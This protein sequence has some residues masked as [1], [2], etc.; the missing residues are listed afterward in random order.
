MAEA[1]TNWRQ[2]ECAGRNASERRASLEKDD[3]QADP[4]AISGKADPTGLN[5]RRV[6]PALRELRK[7][8]GSA[9]IL[10][11]HDLGLVAEQCERV[12]VMYAGHIVEECNTAELFETP[13]H[14]YTQARSRSC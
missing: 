10:I 11:T 2:R 1:F 9:L 14:P 3:V 4:A 7:Q 12:Y 13:R 6:R 5:E 8:L